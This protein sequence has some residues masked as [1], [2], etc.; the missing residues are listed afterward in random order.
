MDKQIVSH[1]YK[2]DISQQKKEHAATWLHLKVL[3]PAREARPR[4]RY[5]LGF[6]YRGTEIRSVV[7]RERGLQKGIDPKGT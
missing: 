3:M 2:G 6:H 5:T 1:L 7:S 4:R